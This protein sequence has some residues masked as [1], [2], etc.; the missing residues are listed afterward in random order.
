MAGLRALAGTD[1]AAAVAASSVCVQRRG[2]FW[3]GGSPSM[4]EATNCSFRNQ[5]GIE[6]SVAICTHT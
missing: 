5:E 2:G 3:H 1:E 6:S 4:R